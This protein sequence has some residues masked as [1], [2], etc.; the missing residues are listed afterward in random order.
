MRSSHA[1]ALVLGVTGLGTACGGDGNGP[2]NTPP[3]AAF[4]PSCALLVCTG[5]TPAPIVQGK[6]KRHFPRLIGQ[7]DE[8][9][10]SHQDPPEWRRAVRNLGGKVS[11]GRAS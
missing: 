3:T 1:L 8:R 11:R 2:S 9:R 4:T 6:R 7:N 5:R 10:Q